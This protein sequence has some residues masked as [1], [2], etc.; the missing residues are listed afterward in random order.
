MSARRRSVAALVAL[1]AALLPGHAAAEPPDA[2]H[3]CRTSSSANG[4]DL[5][6]YAGANRYET[7]ACVAYW[8]W[9][10]HD[11]T[12]VDAERAGAVVLARGDAFPDALAGGPLAGHVNGPLLLTSPTALLP[13]TRAALT[14]VL[15]PGGTVYLLG[16]TGSLSAGVEAAVSAAGYTVKRLAGA[17]RFETA[18][19]IA[20]EMPTTNQFFVTTG[21]DFPDA[22]AAGT[23]AAWHTARA[24][25]KPFALVFTQDARMPASTRDFIATRQ[26][27]HG[28]SLLLY[29]AGG[30]ADRATAGAFGAG[31]VRP[32]VGANRF[33][34]A[35]MIAESLYTDGSGALTGT[36]VGLANGLSFP[37]ALAGTGM[38]MRTGRPLLLT[39]AGSLAPQT[40]VFLRS[41]RG[42]V[43]TPAEDPRAHLDVFGGPGVVAE[44]TAQDALVSFSP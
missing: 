16:G 21:M 2:T 36:G 24:A 30:A 14:R 23:Y 37:D 33:E 22:L 42:E 11:D 41:H 43:S 5:H 8:T 18:I 1:A 25:G 39:A 27:E 20:R 12:A 34:T 26:R 32:F 44:A 9:D 19:R 28:G 7:A 6:R 13:V 3:Q 35:A 29:T 38:L 10:R 4:V 31:Q 15:A 17:N 40:R